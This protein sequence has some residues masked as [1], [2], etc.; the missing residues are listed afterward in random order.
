M[1]VQ[2]VIDYIRRHAP[3]GPGKWPD[4]TLRGW[5][6]TRDAQGKLAIVARNAQVV[7]LGI[8]EERGDGTLHLEL[9]V[10]DQ[11][12][13]WCSLLRRLMKRWPDWRSRRYTAVRHGALRPFPLVR[14]V[15]R[16]NVREEVAHG[17]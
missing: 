9:L 12:W 10:A 17:C 8:A 11:P 3:E 7:A 6:C 5:I 1:T 16:L 14:L 2:T 15:E 4:D 13:L